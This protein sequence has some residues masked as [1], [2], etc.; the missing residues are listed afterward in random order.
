MPRSCGLH[1]SA[2]VSATLRL[3]GIVATVVTILSLVSCSAD[4]T[5]QKQPAARPPQPGKILAFYPGQAAVSPGD[6]AQVCYGVEDVTSV[7]LD[8]PVAEIR[9]LTSK[10]IWFKPPRTMDLTM[11]AVGADGKEIKESI[12]V[13]VKAGAAPTTTNAPAPS[14]GLI[15]TF[16]ATSG[17]IAPGG[18]STICY[19]LREPAKVTLDPSSGE[20]GSDLRKCVLVRPAKTT[21]Y[22]LRA[23]AGGNSDS[24]TVTIKVE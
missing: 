2:L 11:I 7:R 20:L 6:Q 23:A 9:P 22:T 21:V 18:A 24:A 13:T 1:A 12:R 14:T 16:I 8:P 4:T 3:Q 5:Q 15:E 19:V 17:T 10:C